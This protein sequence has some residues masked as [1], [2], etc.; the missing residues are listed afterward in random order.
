[1]GF[2]DL[3]HPWGVLRYTSVPGAPGGGEG[4]VGDQGRVLRG[5]WVGVFALIS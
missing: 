4:P 3:D 2:P 1:M 5:C